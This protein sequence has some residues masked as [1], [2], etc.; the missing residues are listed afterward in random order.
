VIRQITCE[1]GFV[2]RDATEEGVVRLTQAHIAAD[3]RALATS[4]SPDQIRSWIELVPA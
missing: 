1:C 2:A 3:H 4:I